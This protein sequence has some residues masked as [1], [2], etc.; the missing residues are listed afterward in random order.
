[1]AHISGFG[2]A[3]VELNHELFF[4]SSGKI[5]GMDDKTMVSYIVE[6]FGSFNKISYELSQIAYNI[7]FV[8]TAYPIL[9]KHSPDILYHRYSTFNCS[10]MILSFLT[11]KPLILEFNSSALWKTEKKVKHRLKFSRLLIERLNLNWSDIIVVVSLEL[12]RKLIRDGVEGEKVI[13]NFNG[14]DPEIFNPGVPKK[15]LRSVYGID[16]NIIVGFAGMFG[17]WHGVETLVSCIKDV[18]LKN[19]ETHFILIGDGILRDKLEKIAENDGTLQ[20]VTFTGIIAKKEMPC[21]LNACDILVSPHRNMADG[22]RFFGSPIKLFEYM[23]MGKPIVASKVGQLEE[24]FVNERNA[25]L[26]PADD[27]EKLADA[28]LRLASDKSLRERLGG[29]ARID[30]INNY[31]WGHNAKRVIEAYKKLIH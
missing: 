15:D 16:K 20:F 30:L 17:Q 2:K 18:V 28:I 11:K 19:R 25:L 4:V 21:Y 24:I 26:V 7:K 13:I 31:T 8:Y 6:R 3:L 5:S 22:Q 14:A 1:M 27:A 10:G 9:K 23:A 29:Q 12:K